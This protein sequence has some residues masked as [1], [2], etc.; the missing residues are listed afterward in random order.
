[1]E[2]FR[3]QSPLVYQRVELP[4]EDFRKFFAGDSSF[5]DFGPVRAFH[6]LLPLTVTAQVIGPLKR[7]EHRPKGFPVAV[8]LPGDVGFDNSP[9]NLI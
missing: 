4:L 9:E 6:S 7:L 8:H 5:S 1:M 2:I 3:G